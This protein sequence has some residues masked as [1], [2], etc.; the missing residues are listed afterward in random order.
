M[1]KALSNLKLKAKKLIFKDKASKRV[2]P[3][4]EAFLRFDEASY[5]LS[6]LI[7]KLQR[8]KDWWSRERWRGK[9]KIELRKSL[10][11]QQIVKNWKRVNKSSSRPNIL[12]V[13]AE[14]NRGNFACFVSVCFLLKSFVCVFSSFSKLF[15]IKTNLKNECTGWNFQQIYLF[16]DT[17]VPNNQ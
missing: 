15:C 11:W 3:S 16:I 4:H 7:A 14:R 6:A 5:K 8:H 12:Q 9:I 10:A 1:S 17:T 2:V 13:E